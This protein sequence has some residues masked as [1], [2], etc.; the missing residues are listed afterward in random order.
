VGPW[1]GWKTE[2]LSDVEAWFACPVEMSKLSNMPDGGATESLALFPYQ[3]ST[4]D[5][6]TDV[7]N[8]GA[9]ISLVFALY[10]PS[11]TPTGAD[12]S[13]PPNTVTP[14]VAPTDEENR[15]VYDDGSNAE[16]ILT[17]SAWLN[18]APPMLLSRRT[19]LQS[20]GLVIEPAG[21]R[22]AVTTAT[23]TSPCIPPG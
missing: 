1:F 13:T 8:D 9:A 14:A 17:Y 5:P 22:R 10:W 11:A 7:V 20:G 2:A 12:A 16:T 6:F 3:P 21:E 23:S 15:H 18:A 19:S 4:S